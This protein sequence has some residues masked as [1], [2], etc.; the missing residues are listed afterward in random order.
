M[1]Q[2]ILFH[3]DVYIVAECIRRN[4]NYDGNVDIVKKMFENI[5]LFHIFE[6]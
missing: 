4:I 1:F 5:K 3:L 2:E 6:A